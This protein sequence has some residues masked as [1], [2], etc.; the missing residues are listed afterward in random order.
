MDAV[1]TSENK[2]NAYGKSNWVKLIFIYLVIGGVLYAGV[3][4]FVLSKNETGYNQ[5]QTPP[6]NK[7]QSAPATAPTQAS[8]TAAV[9]QT[10]NGV[11]LSSSGFMPQTLTIKAGETVTWENS[12]GGTAT[13]NSDP[14]PIHTNYPPLNLG[15]FNDGGTL[16]LKFD[17]PGAYGYH[18]HLNPSQT[19]K[20]VVE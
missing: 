14:H 6:V 10:Q 8:P 3:Y 17:K 2:S 12:S 18:N 15:Q 9:P 5:T 4:Y 19:G 11:V 13:V 20:I 16:T 1:T 7:E